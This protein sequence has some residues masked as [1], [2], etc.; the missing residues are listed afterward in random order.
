MPLQRTTNPDGYN[1]NITA[2]QTA[3]NRAADANLLPSRSAFILHPTDRLLNALSSPQYGRQ[4]GLGAVVDE[5]VRTGSMIPAKDFLSTDRS[6]YHKSWVPSPWTV[7]QWGLQ[8]IGLA[9]TE[10]YEGTVG[11]R[12]LKTAA[13]VLVEALEKVGAQILAAREKAGQSL[14]DRILSREAFAQDLAALRGTHVPEEDLRLLL[15]YLERDKQALSS[16]DKVGSRLS[17]L[18]LYGHTEM[19]YRLSS[20]KPLLQQLQNL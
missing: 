20:S 8:Q 15:R 6:I 14:T 9:G 19:P 5:S 11:A 1:A 4:L 2:W 16:D 18:L 13:F 3:L 7:L 12:K 10:S 17:E